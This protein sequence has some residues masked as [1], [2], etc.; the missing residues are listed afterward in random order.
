MK[1]KINDVVQ[2]SPIHEWGGC[3]LTVT[4]VKH[5]G[6]QGFV[7]VPMKGQA[8]IRIEHGLYEPIGEAVFTLV[9]EENPE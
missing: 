7:E 5:W 4:E 3:F 9:D 8:Y 2:I 1:A 6:I